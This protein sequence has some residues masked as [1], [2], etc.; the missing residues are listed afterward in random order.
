MSQP[1]TEKKGSRLPPIDEGLRKLMEIATPN[2]IYT[3]EEIAKICKCHRGRI[4]QIEKAALKKLR[5]RLMFGEL[6]T[7]LTKKDLK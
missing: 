4:S 7:V 5:N 1:P 6:K 2:K 3:Q